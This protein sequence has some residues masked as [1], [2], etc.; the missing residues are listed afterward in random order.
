MEKND[1]KYGDIIHASDDSL[2]MVHHIGKLGE[3]HYLAYADAA[4]GR[5]GEPPYDRY[6][7]TIDKCYPATDTEIAWLGQWIYER[8]KKKSNG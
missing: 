1:V 6:Y 5:I 8:M 4:R 3:V 2:V 7:G